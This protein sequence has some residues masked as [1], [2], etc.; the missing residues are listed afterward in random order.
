MN[1][2]CMTYENSQWMFVDLDP[3][4]ISILQSVEAKTAA[5]RDLRTHKDKEHL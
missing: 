4:C 3:L 1:K 5:D 2:L